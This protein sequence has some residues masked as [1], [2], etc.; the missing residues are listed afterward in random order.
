FAAA[1]AAGA[2]VSSYLLHAL[3]EAVVPELAE[4]S[5]TVTWAVPV[6]M[7]GPVRVV[8][9]DANASSL[10]PVDVPRGAAPA[11]VHGAL[12]QALAANLHWGKWDQLR[13][14][15]RLGR[16]ILRKKVA[17]HY[18][19]AGSGAARVGVFSNV[20]VWSGASEPDVGVIAYGVPVLPDPLFAVALTWNGKLALSLRAHP[21]LGVDDATVARWLDA[22]CER[23]L[24]LG[25][26]P[27]AQG[28]RGAA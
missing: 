19:T 9:E 13:T 24:R 6:N 12:Q 14:A 18:R 4:P 15:A 26:S 28:E 8:P 11:A 3:T 22:W 23:A 2:S 1:R 25:A 17:A 5:A 20:G 7:R 16:R 27:L 10:M 21:S